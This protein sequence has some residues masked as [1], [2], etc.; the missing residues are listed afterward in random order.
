MTRGA[1]AALGRQSRSEARAERIGILASMRLND[2]YEPPAPGYLTSQQA[3]WR[4]G[5]SQRTVER[6]RAELKTATATPQGDP[7]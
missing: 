7:A 6:Y 3:A 4:L 2:S 1:A 5:V